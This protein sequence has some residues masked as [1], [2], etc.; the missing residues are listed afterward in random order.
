[1]TYSSKYILRNKIYFNNLDHNKPPLQL[2]DIIFT[3]RSFAYFLLDVDYNYIIVWWILP[4]K[5]KTF[6]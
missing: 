1:M 6:V 2:L 5:Q 3:V 4:R